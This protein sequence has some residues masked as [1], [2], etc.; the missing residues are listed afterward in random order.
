MNGNTRRD[1]YEEAL[2]AYQKYTGDKAAAIRGDESK[3]L[4]EGNR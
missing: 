1:N 4:I 2:R 3:Y